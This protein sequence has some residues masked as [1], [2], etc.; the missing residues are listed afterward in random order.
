VSTLDRFPEITALTRSLIDSL[1]DVAR[2]RPARRN[3]NAGLRTV[4]VLA[5]S[6]TF[7]MPGAVTL[8]NELAKLDALDREAQLLILVKRSDPQAPRSRQRVIQS[9]PE[10]LVVAE[11]KEAALKAGLE[12][13]DLIVSVNDEPVLGRYVLDRHLRVGAARLLVRRSGA[14]REVTLSLDAK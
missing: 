8:Q 5:P 6:L 14:E 7:A 3:L 9:A 12:P 2:F 11:S 4:P 13:D 10:G 1:L